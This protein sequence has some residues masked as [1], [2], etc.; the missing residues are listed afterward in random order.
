MGNKLKFDSHI[1]NICLKANIKFSVLCRLENILTFHFLKH[2][3]N[4]LWMFCSRT[5]N[6]KISRFHERALR[7]LFE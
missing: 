4:I 7:I 2:S 3:L 1:S 5:P 6:N